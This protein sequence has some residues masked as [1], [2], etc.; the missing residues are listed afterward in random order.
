MFI[1]IIA[2]Q[3][4]LDHALILLI[5]LPSPPYLS[6]IFSISV[7]VPRPYCFTTSVNN[8]ASGLATIE[9]KLINSDFVMHFPVGIANHHMQFSFM[10]NI[11]A[12]QAKAF[13]YG[14]GKRKKLLVNNKNM[15]LISPNERNEVVKVVLSENKGKHTDLIYILCLPIFRNMFLTYF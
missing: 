10:E 5:V 14:L 15:D 1:L 11:P 12:M 8:L 9:W 13:I 3:S 2:N 7:E 4:I 6:F